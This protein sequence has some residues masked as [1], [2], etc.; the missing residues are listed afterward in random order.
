L[1]TSF[2]FHYEGQQKIVWSGLN[3][4]RIGF[5]FRKIPELKILGSEL[6][7]DSDLAKETG[8]QN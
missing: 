6:L 5:A 2:G 4:S 3:K 1:N 8:K 7:F